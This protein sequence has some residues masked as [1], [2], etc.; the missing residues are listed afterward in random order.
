MFYIKKFVTFWAIYNT[1]TGASR[2][3]TTKEQQAVT[4]EFPELACRQV[5]TLYFAAVRCITRMP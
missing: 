3:L 5:N 2:M 1:G 4:E